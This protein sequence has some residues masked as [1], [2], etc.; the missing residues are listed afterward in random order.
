M[1]GV[2]GVQAS[3]TS[4]TQI[5]LHPL[6]RQLHKSPKAFSSPARKCCTRRATVVRAS[7]AQQAPASAKA[8]VEQGLEAFQKGDTAAALNLFR[9][10]LSMNAT[11]DEAR[12]ALYNSACCL[13]KEKKWKAAADAVSEACNN[14][15]LKYAVAL[16]VTTAGDFVKA[17]LSS[18]Y[19]ISSLILAVHAAQGVHAHITNCLKASA[20]RVTNLSRGDHHRPCLLVC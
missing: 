10:A 13:V 20:L 17:L 18:L 3:V 14:Y 16:K 4:N 7:T 8:A 11:K 5:S 19:Y 15:G 2:P 6:H 12:A 9:Q 1:P